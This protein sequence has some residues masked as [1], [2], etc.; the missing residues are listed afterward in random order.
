MV[1]GLLGLMHI[2]ASIHGRA[3]TVSMGLTRDF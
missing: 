1:V 2:D 3:T